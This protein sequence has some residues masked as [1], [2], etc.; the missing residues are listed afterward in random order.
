MEPHVLEILLTKNDKVK[1]EVNKDA[2]ILHFVY[3]VIY[4]FCP[5][6]APCL[7]LLLVASFQPLKKW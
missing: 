1:R 5:S 6:D 2:F 3:F 7:H 4:V